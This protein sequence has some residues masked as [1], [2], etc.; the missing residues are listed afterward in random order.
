[1]N[2]SQKHTVF[3]CLMM[4]IL[5]ISCNKATTP[6]LLPVFSS[7]ALMAITDTTAQISSTILSDSGD[8]IITRGVCW[9]KTGNPTITDSIT[10]DSL[11]IGKYTSRLKK[12]NANSTYY[13]RS[14]AT[15]KS[16]TAYSSVA[17]FTTAPVKGFTV[18]D[19][20]GNIYNIVTI[21]AQVWM[22]ENLK[23]TRYNN[24]DTIGTTYPALKDI[25]TETSP[26]YQWAY[27]ADVNLVAKY[28]RLYTNYV[29]T[30]SR[31]IAPAGWHVAT[32]DDWKVLVNYV[33]ANYGTSKSIAKA[34]SSLTDWTSNTTSN[35]IGNNATINNFTGFT[36]MPGGMRNYNT[37]SFSNVGIIGAYWTSTNLV[38]SGAFSFYLYNNQSFVNRNS[39]NPMVGLSVRCIRD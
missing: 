16:G 8:T 17:K 1:M 24:G 23:T 35:S 19:A 2:S 29:V 37:G 38:S 4:V 5:L 20:D 6:D 14:Y 9:N 25:T 7:S 22:V 34:L 11:G 33:S 27:N 32:D 12:L 39:S 26:K 13:F 21:G 30:D 15:N 31:G 3:V 18:T 36:A 10:S 28:G